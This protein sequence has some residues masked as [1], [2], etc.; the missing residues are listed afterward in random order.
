MVTANITKTPA[1]A[2]VVPGQDTTFSVT[3]S[4]AFTPT[5]Y[6]YQW[7]QDGIPIAGATTSSYSIDPVIGDN[8]KTFSVGVYALSG[9]SAGSFATTSNTLT[10]SV[11]EDVTVFSK[12]AVYPETGEERFKRLRHLGYV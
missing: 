2:T 6:T 10:L 8:G 4:A 7:T 5:S 12:F 11:V 1:S 3:T 9:L